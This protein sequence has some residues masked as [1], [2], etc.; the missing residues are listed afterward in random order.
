MQH[1]AQ[2]RG[3]FLTLDI[4]RRIPTLW[5]DTDE[6]QQIVLNLI[7]NA[8]AATSRGGRVTVRVEASHLAPRSGGPEG[9]AVRLVVA[10]TGCGYYETYKLFHKDF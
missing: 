5:V 1:E 10:D 8:L 9:P 7:A 2:R 6:I 3:V 4:P